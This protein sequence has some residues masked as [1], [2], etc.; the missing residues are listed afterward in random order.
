MYLI[1]FL[2]IILCWFSHPNTSILNN[3]LSDPPTFYN[4]DS[5]NQFI[6]NY[7][8]QEFATQEQDY[9]DALIKVDTIDG[10]IN[11]K[12]QLY[13]EPDYGPIRIIPAPSGFITGYLNDDHKKDLI[14]SV[15]STEGGQSSWL[16]IF[17]F[18]SKNNQLQFFRKYTSYDL[19]YCKRVKGKGKFYPAAIINK[20]LVGETRCFTPKDPGCC[21][22]G[23]VKTKFKFSNG[24]QLVSQLK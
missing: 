16:E 13:K 9:P 20:T 3:K 11:I 10:L 4:K 5:I 23:I 17:V 12:H 14:V 24:L 1:H 22:S 18:I 19:G 2:F 8:R 6:I 7:Y 21:P 15:Y